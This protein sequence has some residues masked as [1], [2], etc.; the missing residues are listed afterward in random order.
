MEHDEKNLVFT[1]SIDGS[2]AALAGKITTLVDRENLA[3]GSGTLIQILGRVFICTAGHVIPSNPTGRI[4]PLLRQIRHEGDGFPAYASFGRHPE[5]DVGYLEIHPD[6]IEKYFGGDTFTTIDHIAV[7]GS[8]RPQHSVLV[9]GAPAAH[10]EITRDSRTEMTYKANVMTYWTVPLSVSEWPVVPVVNRPP[11]E[12]VDIFLNYPKDE[13]I[14]A[15]GRGPVDLPNPEGVSG[16]GIWDQEFNAGRVW[17]PSAIKLVGIQVA[18]NEQER[19][20]RGIQIRHWLRLLYRDIPS[21]RP[22][23]QERFGPDVVWDQ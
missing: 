12:S 22:V 17:D 2:R 7:R 5:L 10:R 4:W 13:A 21:L 8:G 18:W 6:A 16:G 20:L 9:V 1:E 15:D 23:L 19:Y 11:D 3:N 14:S